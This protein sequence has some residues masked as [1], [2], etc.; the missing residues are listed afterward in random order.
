M[1]KDSC[2]QLLS[3]SRTGK[4]LTIYFFFSQSLQPFFKLLLG[5]YCR[6]HNPYSLWCGEVMFPFVT[7]VGISIMCLSNTQPYK[8]SLQTL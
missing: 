8:E 2:I 6:S 5:H 4:Y 7:S 1:S 3:V